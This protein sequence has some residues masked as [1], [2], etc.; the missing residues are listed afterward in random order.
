MAGAGLRLELKSW[1]KESVASCCTAEI[2]LNEIAPLNL[3]SGFVK[4]TVC[5]RACKYKPWTL[6]PWVPMRRSKKYFATQRGEGQSK[7]TPG[8]FSCSGSSPKRPTR[9]GC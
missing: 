9:R 3:I 4:Q 8:P 6:S 1:G 2:H 7:N 5:L